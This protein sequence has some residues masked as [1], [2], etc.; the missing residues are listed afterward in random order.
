VGGY[1]E[2]VEKVTAAVDKMREPDAPG[3][4]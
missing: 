3:H 2:A 4:S 1:L